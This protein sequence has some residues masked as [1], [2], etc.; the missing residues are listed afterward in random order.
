MALHPDDPHA[1]GSSLWRVLHTFAAAYSDTPSEHQRA[2]YDAW[3]NLLPEVL[4]CGTCANH[5]DDHL[6][7]MPV[8]DALVNRDAFLRWTWRLHDAVNQ[9]TGV[10]N[11]WSEQQMMQYYHMRR[12]PSPLPLLNHVEP[13]PE[14]APEPA[15]PPSRVSLSSS[16]ARPTFSKTSNA[17]KK[18]TAASRTPPVVLNLNAARNASSVSH[19]VARQPARPSARMPPTK[20]APAPPFSASTVVTTASQRMTNLLAA[21]QTPTVTIRASNAPAQWPAMTQATNPIPVSRPPPPAP[22]QNIQNAKGSL[23]RMPNRQPPPRSQTNLMSSPS[24]SSSSSSMPSPI[25][26]S[27]SNDNI[28]SMATAAR[29]RQTMAAAAAAASSS[30]LPAAKKCKSCAGSARQA[31]SMSQQIRVASAGTLVNR[32]KSAPMPR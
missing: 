29:V 5:L 19:L 2:A 11:G 18:P 15:R 4:P 28:A 31:L 20:H 22:S 14:P 17:I 12:T 6:D 8:G 7:A 21:D 13:E 32:A 9:S 3:I 10:T 1:W 24:M 23:V 16:A 25:R 30:G 26:R 27:A